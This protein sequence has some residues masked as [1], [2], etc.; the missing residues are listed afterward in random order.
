MDPNDILD[1]IV[2]MIAMHAVPS[3]VV[4]EMAQINR[5]LREARIPTQLRPT[6]RYG[7]PTITYQRLY[8]RE[9]YLVPLW[10]ISRRLWDQW[11]S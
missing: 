4:L 5:E 11:N 8:P 10:D 9:A 2:R 7:Q 6:F 1:R 3:E